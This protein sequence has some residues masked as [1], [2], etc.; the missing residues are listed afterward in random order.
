MSH[1][2]IVSHYSS[3]HRKKKKVTFWLELVEA[4]EKK[5]FVASK[6]DWTRTA[7]GLRFGSVLE[8]V[9]PLVCPICVNLCNQY[10]PSTV[11]GQRRNKQ[12]Q[13]TSSLINTRPL[14]PAFLIV[15]PSPGLTPRPQFPSIQ[16][17]GRLDLKLISVCPRQPDETRKVFQQFAS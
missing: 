2:P 16:H 8:N 5:T 9:N 11:C 17:L 6:N 10:C 7:R 1:K 3:P 15:H 13:T 4:P 14:Q 12:L